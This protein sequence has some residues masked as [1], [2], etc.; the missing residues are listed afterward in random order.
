MRIFAST[1]REEGNKETELGQ[2]CLSF[3]RGEREKVKKQSAEKL[4]KKD[5][6]WGERKE[7]ILPSR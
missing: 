7:P 2:A 5:Q 1:T 4:R 6:E 3:D